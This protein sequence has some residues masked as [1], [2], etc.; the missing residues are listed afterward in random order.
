MS[1]QGLAGVVVWND[2]TVAGPDG[3]PTAFGKA[4]GRAFEKLG[5]AL[6]ACAGATVQTDHVW[7]VESQASVRVWWMLDSAQ[8]GMTWVRR[9]S[10][11]ERDHSTSQAARLGWIRLLQDLGIEP[12][13]VAEDAL[14]ERLLRERPRCLVL[15][16]AVALADRTVQAIET[17]ARQ[18]GTVVADH[19]AALYDDRLRRRPAG[20]LDR[21][22]GVAERSFAWSDQL[23]RQGRTVSREEGLPLAERGLRGK[24]GERRD[25]G[26]AF[27]EQTPDRGRAVYLNAPVCM[28]DRWRLDESKVEPARELRRRV[29]GVL[30]QAGVKPPFEVQGEGLPTCLQR[31]VLRLRDGRTVFAVC[32]QALQ[33]PALLKRLAAN[34]PR[35]VQI[36]LPREY[37][38]RHLGGADIGT[39]ANFRVALDPWEALL[40]EVAR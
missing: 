4:V 30:Q 24:L 17:Y 11:Y 8:D 20:G 7:M 40:L 18:G 28:Y 3:A 32:V 19:G 29:R 1:M 14:P 15:P 31:S 6:D 10:S 21:L 26:D 25:G 22:F 38:L 9:L 5:P 34:G 27:L 2:A 33:S 39:A 16:A 23:V 13:F 12:A 36:E 37:H 35:P